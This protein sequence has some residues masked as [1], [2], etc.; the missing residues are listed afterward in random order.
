M[1]IRKLYEAFWVDN[2][3]EKQKEVEELKSGSSSDFALWIERLLLGG[4]TQK[5]YNILT[6]L[7]G[8]I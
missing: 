3:K 2:I 5:E 8:T 4:D 1:I 6:L 7:S